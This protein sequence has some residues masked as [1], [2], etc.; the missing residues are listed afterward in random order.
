MVWTWVLVCL[1]IGELLVYFILAASRKVFPHEITS[2]VKSKLFFYILCLCLFVMGGV[3]F[4]SYNNTIHRLKDLDLISRRFLAIGETENTILRMESAQR[5]FL[6]TSK[7]AYLDPYY[8]NK[9]MMHEKCET[10]KRLYYGTIDQ[11]RAEELCNLVDKKLITLER[12]IELKNKGT[13]DEIEQALILNEGKN[14]AE[15][16]IL[17]GRDLEDREIAEYNNLVAGFW[18][19]GRLRVYLSIVLMVAALTQVGMAAVLGRSR[20]P[21]PSSSPPSSEAFFP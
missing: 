7:K 5:G 14:T 2:P 1:V 3:S 11:T 6:L 21:P 8:K 18:T 10:V 4:F 17:I 16:I 12:N 19:L 13:K 20:T 9:D 15:M